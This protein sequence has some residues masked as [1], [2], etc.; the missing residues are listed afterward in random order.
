M[1][2]STR[3]E[4]PFRA[5]N[6]ATGEGIATYALHADT[7]VEAGLDRSFAA[8]REL[9]VVGIARRAELL[10]RLA[11]VLDANVERL[12]QLM[13]L[14]MGKP[15]NEARG[16][17][18]KCAVT[19]RT[20]AELG[21]EWLAPQQVPSPARASRVRYEGLGPILA[22][23]PWNFPYWQ[24][25]RFFAPAFLDESPVGESLRMFPQ[26]ATQ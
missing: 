23:M 22:V 2:T 8:W 25:I 1:T 17:V 18:R 4:T 7:E 24:V 13:T 26:F 3:A 14:E 16:E 21:P 5:V 10:V 20:T 11:D 19:C 15:I 6:P 12:A 9:R